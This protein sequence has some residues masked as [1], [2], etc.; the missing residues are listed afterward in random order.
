MKRIAV[1]GVSRNP[2]SHGSNFVYK[3][4][5]ERGYEVFPVNPNAVQVEGDRCYPDL[6]SI[7]GG[8]SAVVW[9]SKIT[10]R[11]TPP[12]PGLSA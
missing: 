8:V 12:C 10:S 1:T 3:R 5:R 11:V 9:G 6:K 2:E 4:L 7:P